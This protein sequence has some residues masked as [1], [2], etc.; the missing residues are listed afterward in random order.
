MRKKQKYDWVKLIGEWKKSGE[1]QADFCR[2]NNLNQNMFS[3][4]KRKLEDYEEPCFV[5]VKFENKNSEANIEL[6]AGRF[7]IK[8]KSDFNKVLLKEILEVI[9]EIQ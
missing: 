2:Q 5:E 3:K 6:V 8:I 9:G 7:S 4:Q 1:S